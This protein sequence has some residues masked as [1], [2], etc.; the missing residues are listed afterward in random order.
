[1]QIPLFVL[2]FCAAIGLLL[3]LYTLHFRYRALFM[4]PE[5]LRSALSRTIS[6]DEDVSDEDLWEGLLHLET[7]LG[8]VIFATSLFLL[9]LM[10]L[11]VTL[12]A[13]STLPGLTLVLSGICL[14]LVGVAA[15]LILLRDILRFLHKQMEDER[16]SRGM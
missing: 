6:G 11:C 5:R 15:S 14:L 10:A 4:G 13:L 2:T 8:R 12:T 1:M 9:L 16:T 3:F 7:R